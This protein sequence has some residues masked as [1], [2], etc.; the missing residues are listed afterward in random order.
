MLYLEDYEMRKTKLTIEDIVFFIII[1]L[2][3]FISLWLLIRSPTF[4]NAIISIGVFIATT[5]IFLWR[6]VFSIDKNTTVGFVKV[7]SDIDKLRIEMNNQF[8]NMEGRFDAM[9]NRFDN[10]E[11]KLTNVENWIRRK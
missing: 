6:K 1:G 3:V 4:N 2:I 7:K 11:S 10:M 9:E 8:D 5:E